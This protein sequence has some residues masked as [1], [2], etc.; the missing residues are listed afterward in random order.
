VS[1]EGVAVSVQRIVVK[2]LTM[3]MPVTCRLVRAE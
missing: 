2:H 1:D 3:L